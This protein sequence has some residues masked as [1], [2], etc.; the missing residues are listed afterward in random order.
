MEFQCTFASG[1]ANF[2]WA[3]WGI[4]N[5]AASGTPQAGGTM[6]NRKVAALGSKTTGSYTL[7]VDVTL[8]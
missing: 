5:N 2:T 4:F 8:S 6:L 1:E 3:E 7:T